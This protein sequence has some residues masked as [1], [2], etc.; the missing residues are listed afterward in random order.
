[1]S[2]QTAFESPGESIFVDC[3]AAGRSFRNVCMVQV[4]F[5]KQA[6]RKQIIFPNLLDAFAKLRNA[7]I[8]FA[9]SVCPSV[10]PPLDGFS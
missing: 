9:T 1:L 8:S 5:M 2:Q 3:F 4:N 10:R 6:I 7:T